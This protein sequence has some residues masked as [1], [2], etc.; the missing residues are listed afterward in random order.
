MALH[1]LSLI[2]LFVGIICGFAIGQEKN[3]ITIRGEVKDSLSNKSLS[4]VH[5]KLKGK[6]TGV[7]SNSEGRFVFHLTEEAID[8]SLMFSMIGY[9]PKV[10]PVEELLKKD[11]HTFL[12]SEYT[13]YLDEVV[14]EAQ[15][16]LEIIKE[17]TKRLQDNFPVEPFEFE[18]FYRNSYK[19]FDKYVRQFEAA[20]SGFDH[21]FHHRSGYSLNMLKR[22]ESTDYRQSKWRQASG[23]IPWHYLWHIRRQHQYFFTNKQ[24]LKYDYTIESIDSFEGEQVYKLKFILK[25]KSERISES[26]AY[27]RE[28]DYAILEIGGKTKTINPKK[29]QLSDSLFMAY[30]GGTIQVKYVE[31]KGKMYPSYSNSLYQHQ[32]YNA[33]SV[34]QGSFDMNEEL[35]IHEIKTPSSYVS[36]KAF[37]KKKQSNILAL[38]ADSIFWKQYNK[39]VATALS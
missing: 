7:P 28:K 33:Q 20:F 32:V 26:W 14:I 37:N 9:N 13:T 16:A 5:I 8:D 11:F 18:G 22:K 27:I 17:V 29:F 24:Y 3:S 39:P 1:K 38:P 30:T 36:K 34:G 31:F 6:S 25:D 21:N 12:I 2:V 15:D 4:F 35:I 23:N 10:I 19:E